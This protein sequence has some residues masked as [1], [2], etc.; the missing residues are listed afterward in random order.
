MKQNDLQKLR[1]NIVKTF[2]VFLVTSTAISAVLFL[3]VFNKNNKESELLFTTQ[4]T[5]ANKVLQYSIY[6]QISTLI[7][8]IDFISFI[9]S[10]DLSRQRHY[11]NI[12]L[13]CNNLDPHL[14]RGI[15]IVKFN[16]ISKI[17]VSILKYGG[18]TKHFINLDICYLNNRA[19]DNLGDCVYKHINFKVYFNQI[20]YI[21]QLNSIDSTIN[22]APNAETIYKFYPFSDMLVDF[23]IK[24]HSVI[25]LPLWFKLDSKMNINLF[26]LALPLFSIMLLVYYFSYKMIR[27]EVENKLIVPL[28]TISEKL[29]KGLNVPIKE[30]YLIELN[31][32][33][34]IV[35]KY[36]TIQLNDR[37]NKIAVRVAHDIK[38]PLA[39]IELSIADVFDK[40]N[41]KY[42]IIKNAIRSLQAI[43]NNMLHNYS[44]K[45]TSA[46]IFD[47]KRSYVLVKEIIEEIVSLKL[48]EW[49]KYNKKFTLECNF[50]N[51]LNYWVLLSTIEFKRHISNLLQNSFEAIREE[52][53]NIMVSVSNINDL[54]II[55]ISDN[56]IGMSNQMV[57]LI[58][59]G[60]SSKKDGQGIGLASAAAYFK[61]E[62]AAFDVKSIVGTGTAINISLNTPNKPSWFAEIIYVN[63]NLVIV[64]DEKSML[65]FWVNK[66]DKMD[67]N[68]KTFTSPHLFQE[69]YNNL[70]ND[71]GYTFIIDYDYND[72]FYGIDLIKKIKNTNDCFLITSSYNDY[73]IQYQVTNLNISLIPK[74]LLSEITIL[75]KY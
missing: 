2:V 58:K 65:D 26:W 68:I 55:T 38:S 23:K 60:Q 70:S 19:N 56:G 73:E 47:E 53:I 1:D 10:G 40:H 35:N 22:I 30:D 6:N 11:G 14:F 17:G 33:I 59:F 46:S 71:L 28:N 20:G 29:K 51:L 8:N 32:L 48:T 49:S 69:W 57:D 75:L 13:L 50:D 15:E 25:P 37:L 21:K 63:K 41:P 16:P 36:N 4:V 74:Y 45:N 67:L 54:T 43:A 7:N 12:L 31:N 44:G 24:N 64:D 34:D 9:V 42:T 3:Y 52:S 18:A 27:R 62:H 66:F 61:Y 72:N 5:N 39:V